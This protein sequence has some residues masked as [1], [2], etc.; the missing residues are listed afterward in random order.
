M[1]K[2]DFCKKVVVY[3]KNRFNV[4]GPDG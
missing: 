4:E 3:G 2:L 1:K